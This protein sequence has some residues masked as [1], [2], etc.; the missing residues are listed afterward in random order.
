MRKFLLACVTA[1]FAVSGTAA[2]AADENDAVDNFFASIGSFDASVTGT[3]DYTF[4]GI[5]QTSEDPAIQGSFGW[6]KDFKAGQQDIGLYASVW[7]SNVEFKDGDNAHIEI[8]YTAGIT[9]TLAGVSLDAFAI[10]YSYPGANDAL[11]YDYIEAGFGAGYDFGV[12]ALNGAFYWSPDFFGGI[13]DAYYFSGDVSVPLPFKLT[14]AGHIGYSVFDSSSTEDYADW[15]ISLTR[16]I[17]G[18]DLSVAYVDTELDCGGNCDSRGV[19]TVSK[20]F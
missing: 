2:L 12:A 11:D 7:G 19:F 1:C 17:L 10:Y 9:T 6:S 5:S 14:A 8:D 16:N 13:G 18:F 15:S 3:T 20:S 4:R